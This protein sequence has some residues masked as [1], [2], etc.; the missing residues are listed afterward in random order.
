MYCAANF[1]KPIAAAA[2]QFA[3][4]QDVTIQLSFGGSG[5]LLNNLEV[6]P[7][8]DLYLAAD[9]S[10]IALGRE[11]GLLDEAIPLA[12]QTPVIAVAKG[13]PKK[14][15]ALDDLLRTDVKVVLVNTSGSI[16]K[17]GK[18]ILSDLGIWNALEQ[19]VT[20]TGVFKPTVTDAANDLKI[21]ALD[22]GIVWDSTV[23]QF[24]ELEAV[25]VEAF[26]RHI[27]EA[28]VA[29]L[30]RCKFPNAAL[31][32]ARY[33]QAPEKGG[34]ILKQ[35]GFVTVDGDT[36][37]AQPELTLFSGAM[38][39]PAIEE[40]I[41]AFEAREGV[42]VNR[43][44][45]GCGSLVSMMK[46]GGKPDAFFACDQS[47][48]EMVAERMSRG[49]VLTS[50]PIVILTARGNPLGIQ[51]LKDLL[52]PELKIALGHPEKSALGALTVQF[53]KQEGLYAQ[54]QAASERIVLASKGDDLVNMLR[55]GSRD[56]AI[57]FASNAALV[58][59]KCDSI[60]LSLP[61][62][63]AV[64]PYGVALDS[65]YRYL[66]H[67]LLDRIRSAESRKRFEALGFTW[68]AETGT[69]ETEAGDP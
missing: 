49:T 53:F 43:V 24:P 29:V 35:H 57:V 66:L 42:T 39:R 27:E 51:Y 14:I 36:W 30:K 21:G 48:Y 4:E 31:A 19:H 13:N 55:V 8:G 65:R 11:K 45:E 38:L 5:T 46:A 17:L 56:A 60:P 34:A 2:K 41:K 15:R 68:L 62:A 58:H 64:Q 54:L 12:R 37:N 16:G 18:K 9:A 50:N 47:F 69:P 63:R 7:S 40:T 3:A 44:Y 25:H 67:R 59:E 10:Y 20:A 26:D 1:N 23:A 52:R 61:Q 28:Q 33:L 6:D 22:A 32:F